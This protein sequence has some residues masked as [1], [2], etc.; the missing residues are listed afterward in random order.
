VFLVADQSDAGTPF[1][2]DHEYHQETHVEPGGKAFVVQHGNMAIYQWKPDYRVE[3]HK[4]N[5]SP[6]EPGALRAQP[7]RLLR[8]Q[9]QVVPFDV[10]RRRG[11]I[12]QLTAWRDRAGETAALLLHAPGGQGKTRLANHVAEIANAAGWQVLQAVLNRVGAPGEEFMQGDLSASGKVG[13]MVIVDYAEKWPTVALLSLMQDPILLGRQIPLRFLLVSRPAGTWWQSISYRITNELQIPASRI[14]LP[15]LAGRTEEWSSILEVARDAFAEAYALPESIEVEIP[16]AVAR[17]DYSLVLAAH[18]AA[19]AL[20][21][22]AVHHHPAPS[23][24]TAVTEYLLGRERAYWMDLHEADPVRFPTNSTVMARTVFTATLTRPIAY[25]EAV[26]VLQRVE[27][28]ETGQLVGAVLADHAMCYPPSAPGTVLEPLYPDRLGEDFIA[29]SIPV[30]YGPASEGQESIDISDPWAANAVSKLFRIDVDERPVGLSSAVSTLVETA[31]RWSH[32]AEQQLFPAVRE[33][34]VL[35]LLAGGTALAAFSELPTVPMDLLEA[36]EQILPTGRGSELAI[37]RAAVT[38][39]LSGFRLARAKSPVQQAVIYTALRRALADAGL[40]DKERLAADEEVR[41]Y[42]ALARAEPEDFTIPLAIALDAYGTILLRTGDPDAGIR[43]QTEAVTIYHRLYSVRPD[44]F[45]SELARTLTNLGNSLLR[46]HL[47]NEALQ[48]Q[49]EAVRI[50]RAAGQTRRVI[51]DDLGLAGALVQLSVT[52]THHR[53]LPEALDLI[54]EAVEIL[55]DAMNSEDVEVEQGTVAHAL[56]IQ[57]RILIL[58]DRYE[59]S[60]PPLD[61]AIAILRPLVLSNPAVHDGLL[62]QALSQLGVSLLNLERNAEGIEA[63]EEAVEILSDIPA[64][65]GLHGVEPNF[66]GMLCNLGVA[67]TMNGRPDAAV[68]VLGDAVEKARTLLAN[69]PHEVRFLPWALQSL[70][71]S[72]SALQRWGAA[73][74][75]AEESEQ[76]YRRLVSADAESYTERWHKALGIL[77]HILDN[78]DRQE[79]ASAVRSRAV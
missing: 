45:G 63:L 29:L 16:Q 42:R 79:E 48:V 31:G 59:E 65:F 40:N 8:A 54:G 14:K 6:G 50:R 49:Q 52:L 69:D 73:L 39:R 19:L 26:A 47:V 32:I 72:L 58:M 55:R 2:L 24:S 68:P 76:F 7:S 11:E 23:G 37:G 51:T 64:R 75:A 78:L 53:R 61:E 4:F 74:P 62:S 3:Q 27:A 13:L 43:A 25:E 30:Q 77:A 17:D 20:V 57:A 44:V 22:A 12:E 1:N 15:P 60:V 46:M 67:L 28:I 34:P 33:Q 10:E 35:M 36:I 38:E 70:A 71:A 18:M 21:D 9:Y 41:L 56:E 5:V 66:L